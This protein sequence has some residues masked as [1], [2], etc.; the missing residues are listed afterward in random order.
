ML[1]LRA[2]LSQLEWLGKRWPVIEGKFTEILSQMDE[3]LD[4]LRADPNYSGVKFE[5]IPNDIDGYMGCSINFHRQQ[6]H[7]ALVHQPSRSSEIRLYKKNE[8][9]EEAA[10]KPRRKVV[11]KWEMDQYGN[12]KDINGRNVESGFVIA[13]IG[14]CFPLTR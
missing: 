4:D 10:D 14:D 12:V 6:F 3:I 8:N 7:L 5:M 11:A 2:H 1:D 13:A 9:I